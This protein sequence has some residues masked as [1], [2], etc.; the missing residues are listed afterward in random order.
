LL[1]IVQ[2]SSLKPA[3]ICFS[4]S[5]VLCLTLT[6]RFYEIITDVR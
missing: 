1:S 5:T 6:L 2:H 3:M 4:R